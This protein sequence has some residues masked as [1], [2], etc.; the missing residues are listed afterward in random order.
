[1]RLIVLVTLWC[2]LCAYSLDFY[3]DYREHCESGV[4][5]GD[6]FDLENVSVDEYRSYRAPDES[7]DGVQV[8]TSATRNIFSYATFAAAVNFMYAQ[9]RNYHF[10]FIEENPQ[11][12]DFDVK[13]DKDSRWNKV[14]YLLE[15]IEASEPT[16]KYIMWLDA[17]L[18]V[19]NV[20][21]SVQS[22]FA[23]YPD[24]HILMSKDKVDAP[25]VGNSGCIIV[26]VSEWSREFLK[27][28]WSAYDRRR[29]CDQNA[30]TWLYDRHFP[31]DI[32]SKLIFLDSLEL[33]T[34]FPAYLGPPYR[35]KNMLHLAGLTTIYR[36]RVFNAAYRSLKRW[37]ASREVKPVP[38]LGITV[39]FLQDEMWKMGPMRLCAL[40]RLL[41]C[42]RTAPSHLRI[43]DVRSWLNDVTKVDDDE[44]T[45]AHLVLSRDGVSETDRDSHQ[46]Q[47]QM[48]RQATEEAIFAIHAAIRD[49]V[50]RKAIA[51]LEEQHT[52]LDASVTG[53]STPIQPSLHCCS[54]V[55]SRSPN[56][57]SLNNVCC[58]VALSIAQD[59]ITTTFELILSRDPYPA[60]DTALTFLLIEVAEVLKGV[61]RHVP[62]DMKA[63]HARFEYYRFKMFQLAA[64]IYQQRLQQNPPSSAMDDPGVQELINILLQ[65]VEAW[66]HLSETYHYYG[67][68]YVTADPH[69]EYVDLSMHLGALLCTNRRYQEGLLVLRDAAAKQAEMVRA[70]DTIRIATSSIMRRGRLTLGELWTNLALCTYDAVSNVK[71]NTD[72][73]RYPSEEEWL[74]WIQDGLQL[75]EAD[76]ATSSPAYQQLLDMSQ[77][78]F[79]ATDTTR[80]TTGTPPTT[81]IETPSQI[82]A[83]PAGEKPKRFRRK[84]PRV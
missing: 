66:Q 50:F 41:Q 3:S 44:D 30:L 56:T 29:C 54:D 62:H 18:I 65:A 69:K 43:D 77:I 53:D 36:T 52:S 4:V 22:L 55:Q 70:Y 81:I 82:H 38:L 80:T 68:D 76:D 9:W 49:A 67:T 26:K 33:N 19:V 45:V 27:L 64:E 28:W 42:L 13:Y 59:A 73:H 16:T 63:V 46:Q 83:P 11:A 79:S 78:G 32:Q 23:E 74:Q 60:P 17:D 57:T 84:K 48:T 72:R 58:S 47:R 7:Y 25:F 39:E 5:S 2:A 20:D 15:H 35:Y 6:G 71:S 61:A 51:V 31:D 10:S 12:V 75:F 14:Q 21:F 37:K 40:Q 1:M 24:A 34:E 8:I